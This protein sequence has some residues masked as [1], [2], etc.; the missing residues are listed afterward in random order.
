MKPLIIGGREFS[1][2]LFVGTG[3][4]SSNELMLDSI[5]ASESEMITVSMKRI[6]MENKDDEML[7]H[8]NREKV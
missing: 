7:K 8:I 1:S 2:R 5:I 6:D 3:K 4:F